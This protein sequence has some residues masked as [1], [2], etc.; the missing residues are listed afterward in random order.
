M[1]SEN[2]TLAMDDADSDDEEPPMEDLEDD[3]ASTFEN[4]VDEPNSPPTLDE[5]AAGSGDD[6][7]AIE[8]D[9]LE[10]EESTKLN[11]DDVVEED[12][13]G[14]D[15]LEEELLEQIAGDADSETQAE[16]E[17]EMLKAQGLDLPE[18]ELDDAISSLIDELDGERKPKTKEAD[19]DDFDDF[20]LD[21]D[22]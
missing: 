13:F 16:L 2:V 14:V 8:M 11:K 6:A 10:A 15:D 17:Q 19:Q 9:D 4:D 3:T 12:D 20:G 1:A 18:D 22:K 5:R 7:A 21:D